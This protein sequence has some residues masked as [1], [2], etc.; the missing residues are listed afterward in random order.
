MTFADM[1]NDRG[2][3]DRIAMAVG[4]AITQLEC[5]D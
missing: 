5:G 1:A 3:W 4:E 2:G